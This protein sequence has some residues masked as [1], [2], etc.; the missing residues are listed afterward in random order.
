MLLKD[1]TYGQVNFLF[2]SLFLF[3]CLPTIPAFA[4]DNVTL[5]LKWTHAFQFAGY[6][7]AKAQGYYRDEGIEVNIVEATPDTDP[8]R[9][10]LAGKA[11]Y[12]VGTSSLLLERAAGKPVVAL[13]V[14]FQQS[15]YEIY[16]ASNIH[17]LKDLIGKRIMLESQSQ[18]LLA[19][20]KKRGFH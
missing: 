19:F 7:A 9:D 12:G 13:A 3:V 14:V 11:H 20:L 17:S 16:A 10:V 8:V 5:Q 18:E 15:P 1:F 4:L 6:Y 2:R